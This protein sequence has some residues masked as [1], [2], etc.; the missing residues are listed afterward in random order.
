[1]PE[2]RQSQ[3]ITSGRHDQLMCLSQEISRSVGAILK[4]VH[5]LPVE[6]RQSPLLV[7]R[8]LLLAQSHVIDQLD[9]LSEIEPS[10]DRG[11][12]V[13]RPATGM[14][15]QPISAW[16]NQHASDPAAADMADTFSHGVSQAVGLREIHTQWRG[17]DDRSNLDQA[18]SELLQQLPTHL[19]GLSSSIV[20]H[21]GQC[22]ESSRQSSLHALHGSF[23]AIVQN[24]NVNAV[25]NDS[26][27]Q[28]LRRAGHAREAASRHQGE[29]TT[30]DDP[31]WLEGEIAS[32][33]TRLKNAIGRVVGRGPLTRPIIV[34]LGVAAALA[35]L[36]FWLWAP[37]APR[38][39]QSGGSAT[40]NTEETRS[41][42]PVVTAAPLAKVATAS[43]EA[44]ATTPTD[45]P[46]QAAPNALFKKAQ[47]R[48]S[49]SAAEPLTA[50]DADPL[51]ASEPRASASEKALDAPGTSA[52]AAVQRR[53][54]QSALS[55]ADLATPRI[56]EPQTSASKKLL[57]A[58][59]A[60]A[61]VAAPPQKTSSTLSSA[62]LATP[63][64][65]E[66]RTTLA[67]SHVPKSAPKPKEPARQSNRPT[68]SAPQS[69]PVVGGAKAAPPWQTASVAAAAQ[70]FVPV[71]VTLKYKP[72]AL[73]IFEDLQTRHAALA[74]KK[75]ELR[76]FVGPDGKTWYHVVAVPAVTEEEATEVCHSLG[77]EGEAL[78]C[79]VAPY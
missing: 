9:H 70:H 11:F 24:G 8:E 40:P 22:R 74:N 43:N 68:A 46:Q 30:L 54:V 44:N 25:P 1:M 29:A 58:A 57:S 71:L 50:T 64:I 56:S 6:K 37:G 28:R 55:S 33:T 78:D 45:E 79:T 49:S 7:A 67:P 17:V 21:D 23:F 14:H 66:A 61:P 18:A 76:S 36:M 34:K 51:T 5:G 20:G 59:A 26:R 39:A 12:E 42:A 10:V 48:L 3:R 38:S 52:P 47:S 32:P 62:D 2:L 65:S 16:L 4:S 27:S 77:S 72:A 69:K 35:S 41:S 73:Q 31:Q 63:A 60:S 19:A 13:A 53:E 15:H 75:A